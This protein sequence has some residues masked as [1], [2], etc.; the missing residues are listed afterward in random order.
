MPHYNSNDF[1]TEGNRA[2][3]SRCPKERYD[4][5]TGTAW[6]ERPEWAADGSGKI[7]APLRA[8]CDLH[9]AL[10]GQTTRTNR[11]GAVTF[12]PD[13]IH[14]TMLSPI[15]ARLVEGGAMLL[16][17]T[18]SDT[19]IAALRAAAARFQ[20]T[21]PVKAGKERTAEQPEQLALREVEAAPTAPT[22]RRKRVGKCGTDQPKTHTVIRPR[23]IDLLDIQ[24]DQHCKVLHVTGIAYSRGLRGAPNY[25]RRMTRSQRHFG[26]L[27][28][29]GRMSGRRLANLTSKCFIPQEERDP[30]R[31]P[32]DTGWWGAHDRAHNRWIGHDLI[33]H[34]LP[35]RSHDALQAAWDQV[36]AFDPRLPP[37]PPESFAAEVV[38]ADLIQA[39][40][41]SR[42]I[43]ASS[44]DPIRVTI[45]ARMPGE[46]TALLERAGLPVCESRDNPLLERA[47]TH[48]DI[49]PAL[50]RLLHR[51][52][53]ER[54]SPTI[55]AL[56][57][58]VRAEGMRVS[59]E[60]LMEFCRLLVPPE[61]R[62][63]KKLGYGGALVRRYIVAL[64]GWMRRA[65][66]ALEAR[67][68]TA[69]R[70]VD[71]DLRGLVRRT[72]IGLGGW[73]GWD[74]IGATSAHSAAGPPL[75]CPT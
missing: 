15:G 29:S 31:T 44:S 11:G 6:W 51:F 35:W 23:G 64:M 13:G 26:A 73:L 57:E 46:L 19:M 14:L 8:I 27:R 24:V 20:V 21:E 22:R 50:M 74:P 43:Y 63:P 3:F 34:S 32:A 12:G 61:T 48:H 2:N 5:T 10:A 1:V 59:T 75:P 40:G 55:Q 72:L 62:G 33:I 7:V 67:A 70:A 9:S 38:G 37:T 28:E 68:E 4:L 56:A 45:L 41:R 60:T 17:A 30:T 36:R 39:I 52:A 42:A 53:R 54:R 65:R 18:I 49:A 66:L 58:G 25:N 71:D 47:Q 69:V 16:D